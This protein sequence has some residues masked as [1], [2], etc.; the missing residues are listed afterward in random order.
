[1]QINDLLLNA[2]KTFY[3]RVAYKAAG[4]SEVYCRIERQFLETRF[5]TELVEASKLEHKKQASCAPGI[6]SS[7]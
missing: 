1:M 2:N 7:Y 6:S 4:R 3:N 5:Y